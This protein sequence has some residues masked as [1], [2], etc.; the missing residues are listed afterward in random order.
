MRMHQLEPSCLLAGLLFLFL[1][2]HVQAHSS[3]HR[4]HRHSPSHPHENHGRDLELNLQWNYTGFQLFDSRVLSRFDLPDC[5]KVALQRP[6]RCHN[7][8]H[9]WKSPS[10]HKSLFNRQLTDYICD[11]TCGR[12]LQDYYNQ[13]HDACA[14]S[15]VQG[16]APTLRAG[17]LWAGFNETCLRSEDGKDYCNGKVVFF[18]TCNANRGTI[19]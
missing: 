5:C 7:A 2:V 13:V 18:Q 4:R 16:A 17:W 14:G 8:V 9:S 15:E 1:V 12:S 3:Q 11:P 19:S 6:I 10:Y